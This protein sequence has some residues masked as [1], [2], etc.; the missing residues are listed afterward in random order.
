M[1]YKLF[2]AFIF[3]FILVGSAAAQVYN[4]A[5]LASVRDKDRTD[6]AAD[7]KYATLTASDHMYRADVYN[8]NRAFPEA[9]EHWLIVIQNFPSDAGMSKALFGM[10]RSLM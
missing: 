8:S 3:S 4:D 5:T 10:G 6:R 9:R 7:G 2:L 1:R